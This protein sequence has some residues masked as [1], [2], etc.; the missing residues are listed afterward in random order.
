[1]TDISNLSVL[2][3]EQKDYRLDALEILLI[4][5]D[6][7]NCKTVLNEQLE[8]NISFEIGNKV[9]LKLFRISSKQQSPNTDFYLCVV[10]ISSSVVECPFPTSFKKHTPKNSVFLSF[11]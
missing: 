2:H 5:R 6:R 11:M 3:T 7:K 4:A 9:Q 8:F 10:P 1:M